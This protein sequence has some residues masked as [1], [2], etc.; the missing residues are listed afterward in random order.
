MSIIQFPLS[1][2]YGN[3]KLTGSGVGPDAGEA[4]KDGCCDPAGWA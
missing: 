2:A 1:L 4:I 3:E